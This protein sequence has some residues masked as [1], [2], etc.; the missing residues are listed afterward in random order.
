MRSPNVLK[1]SVVALRSKDQSIALN[2]Y[3]LAIGGV[4]FTHGQH[5]TELWQVKDQFSGIF[6]ST[7]V[8]HPWQITP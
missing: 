1:L 2:E 8:T 4:F 3:I 5:L 6:F 7:F